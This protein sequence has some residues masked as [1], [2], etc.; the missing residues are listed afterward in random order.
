MN[1]IKTALLDRLTMLRDAAS[2]K[3]PNTKS[4]ENARE[5]VVSHFVGRHFAVDLNESGN[6]VFR[7]GPNGHYDQ[8]EIEVLDDGSVSCYKKG[9]GGQ[10][11]SKQFDTHYTDDKFTV[12][13]EQLV[14]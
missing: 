10:N 1:P 2:E 14:E 12:F 9:L 8:A 13:F 3:A 6:A 4:L 5:I 7:F 11:D